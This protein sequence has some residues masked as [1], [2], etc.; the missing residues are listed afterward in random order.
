MNED[1]FKT[2]Q[3]FKSYISKP[4]ITALDPRFLVK[5]SKNVLIDYASRVVSRNGYT[6]FGAVNTGAG[7]PKGSYEWDT[8]TRKQFPL[9]SYDNQLEFYW[10]SRWNTLKSDLPTPY[11]EFAKIWDN[12]EKIDV[13]LYVLGDTNTY[14][15]SGGATTLWKTTGT[16]LTKQGVLTAKTTISFVAGTAGTVA[17]TILDSDSNFLNAG[18]AAGDTLFVTG[19]TAN[20]RAFT[21]GSVTAGV[22]TLIMSDTLATEGAGPSITVHNGEPTWAASRFLTSGT[23]KI[24]YNGVEYTYTGGEG[25]DTLTGLTAFPAVTVGDPV[26]QSVITLA[27]PVAINANFKQDLI[28]VQL[29][30]LILASTKSQEIYGSK[31]IDYTDFTLTSPRNP[32]DPFKVTMDN[33]CTCIIPVDNL[34][35]TASSLLFGGGTNEFFKLS[36]YMSQDNTSEL[37]RMIKLKTASG[38]GV[39]AKGGIAAIKNANVYISREPS[40]EALG[41]IEST[42]KKNIPLSDLIK[43]DFDG[44]DFTDCHVRY[45]KRGIYVALPR[46]GLVLIYDQIRGLWQ[47]P[48]T[49]PVSRLVIISDELYGHSSLSNETYKLFVGTNDNGNFIPQIA[50][51]AYNNGGRRDRLKNMSEYWSDGY[52]SANGTLTMGVYLGFEGADGY[53]MLPISGGDT[54]I[55]NPIGAS[56]YGSEPYGN[57]PYGGASLGA[58]PGLLLGSQTP[59][60]RFYQIDTMSE[61]DY[62]EH[63]VEYSMNTLDG[64]FAIVAHGSNQWDCGAVPVMHKK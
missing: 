37:V 41:T 6:V 42:D 29:N 53:K 7:S 38:S 55:V 54:D 17:P 11:L 32:V 4:E 50:R 19:S 62:M 45:W 13:L 16:T 46:E 27:N 25:T 8:S 48:Q 18:F 49:I 9:R 3:G 61:I 58:I 40:L 20:N 36:Y 64:Q 10:R 12:T 24:V 39:I 35:Q 26:W 14:K 5:G 31:N 47:P 59:L 43:N 44:Y 2:T 56:P 23:R 33:Y 63:F 60:L 34:E 51:F 57:V 15:W 1:S 22:I 52:I 28:G 30:Q 21:I